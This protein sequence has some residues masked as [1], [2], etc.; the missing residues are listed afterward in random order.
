MS[1]FFR[2][3]SRRRT[4]RGIKKTDLPVPKKKHAIICTVMLLDGTDYTTEIHVS[5]LD[6]YEIACPLL[7]SLDLFYKYW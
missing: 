3:L 7:L 5:M 6:T 4:G 2:F 1:R